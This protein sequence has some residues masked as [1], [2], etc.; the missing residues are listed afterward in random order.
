M[1]GP[2]NRRFP[3]C[4]GVIL[5]NGNRIVKAKRL[6]A[7]GNLRDLFERVF[8]G[9]V[10]VG[11]QTI[12]GDP[13]DFEFACFLGYS[14]IFSGQSGF[15]LSGDGHGLTFPESAGCQEKIYFLCLKLF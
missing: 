8:F 6:N 14:G 13:F 15:T 4:Q 5:R 11:N 7:G 2:A 1:G 12:N 3:A 9:I 10:G